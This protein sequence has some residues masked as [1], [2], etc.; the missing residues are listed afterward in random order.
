MK[1]TCSVSIKNTDNQS[2]TT[3]KRVNAPS[4]FTRKAVDN[5]YN[6]MTLMSRKNKT[7]LKSPFGSIMST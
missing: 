7:F 5:S 2:A 3:M 1:R 6:N 4:T